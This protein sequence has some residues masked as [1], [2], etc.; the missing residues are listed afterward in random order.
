MALMYVTTVSSSELEQWVRITIKTVLLVLLVVALSLWRLVLTSWSCHQVCRLVLVVYLRRVAKEAPVINQINC[1]LMIH[2]HCTPA[3]EYW[4][5]STDFKFAKCKRFYLLNNV[6]VHRS[7]SLIKL[8][9]WH[10]FNWL[11]GFYFFFP[12]E[13]TDSRG[14]VRSY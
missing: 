7:S 14:M 4:V 3:F 12:L 9:S 2:W 1:P 13:Q 10:R 11:P 5:L 8:S 6:H